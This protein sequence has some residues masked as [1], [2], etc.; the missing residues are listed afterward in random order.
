MHLMPTLLRLSKV[1]RESLRDAFRRAAWLEPSAAHPNDPEKS[2]WAAFEDDALFAMVPAFEA[3]L[4]ARAAEEAG[5]NTG[6]DARRPGAPSEA[7][8]QQ[9]R[10]RLTDSPFAADGADEPVS[11]QKGGD[12][13]GEFLSDMAAPFV[14]EV[15]GFI[16]GGNW[17]T[18]RSKSQAKSSSLAADL[19]NGVLPTVVDAFTDLLDT[20]EDR[21]QPKRKGTGTTKP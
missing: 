4:E 14:G 10:E 5:A 15:A 12:S 8:Q 21:T 19:L 6:G 11:A 18:P 3:I 13:F 9:A 7:R 17:D 1:E 2:E 16:I 20:H